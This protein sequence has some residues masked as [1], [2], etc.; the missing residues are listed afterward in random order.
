MGVILKTLNLLDRSQEDFVSFDKAQTGLFANFEGR[1]LEL[2]LGKVFVSQK[3]KLNSRRLAITAYRK[4]PP[5][6][7]VSIFSMNWGRKV[8]VWKTLPAAE[9]SELVAVEKVFR[10]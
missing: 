8:F 7:I 6:S 1:E 3:I 5:F 10:Q 4:K 9:K 2:H